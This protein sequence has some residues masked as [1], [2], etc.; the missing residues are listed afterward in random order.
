MIYVLDSSGEELSISKKKHEN[1]LIFCKKKNAPF[2]ILKNMH[3]KN[4]RDE[5]GKEGEEH[6]QVFI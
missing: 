4:K 2:S 1:G 6:S 3:V 5:L